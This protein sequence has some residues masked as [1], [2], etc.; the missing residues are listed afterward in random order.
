LIRK[1]LTISRTQNRII[2]DQILPALI[3][4]DQA[5]LQQAL[6]YL[7]PLIPQFNRVARTL[8]AR[9]CAQNK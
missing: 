3:A 6:G 8:G 7:K 5:G 4:H 9:I 2:Q 1:L